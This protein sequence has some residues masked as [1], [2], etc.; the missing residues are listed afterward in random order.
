MLQKVRAEKEDEKSRVICLASMF[1]SRVVV[2]KLFKKEHFLQ[3]CADLNKKL[4]SVKAV[5]IYASESSHY[6]LLENGM[7]NRVPSHRSGDTGD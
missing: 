3:F 6:T 4:K 7:F 5:Y 1:P 2:L